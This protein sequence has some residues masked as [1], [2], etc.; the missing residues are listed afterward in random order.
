M[1]NPILVLVLS[2]MF[3]ANCIAQNEYCQFIGEISLVSVE[4]GAFWTCTYTGNPASCSIA[5]AA[6]NC[7]QNPACEGVVK[8]FV[9]EGCTYT[10]EVVDDKIKIM[11]KASKEKMFELQRTWEFLNTVQ[12][13]NWL[14]RVLSGG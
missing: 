1:K 14:Q 13:I 7:G 11:G 4:A 5:L 3:S 8:S 9:E 6:H 12:G 2:V 10:V